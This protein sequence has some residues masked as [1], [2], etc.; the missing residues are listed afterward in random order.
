MNF[1]SSSYG[2]TTYGGSASGGAL[3]VR[4]TNMIIRFN[5][6]TCLI[7]GSVKILQPRSKP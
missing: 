3:V 5:R 1:G 6:V 4:I 2:S 7:R